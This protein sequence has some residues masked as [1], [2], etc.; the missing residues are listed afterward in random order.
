[1]FLFHVQQKTRQG[2]FAESLS[3]KTGLS[4]GG[5]GR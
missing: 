3:W 1:L 2:N 4:R 5:R